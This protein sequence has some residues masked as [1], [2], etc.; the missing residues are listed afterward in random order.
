[1]EPIP[2]GIHV[3][4]DIFKCIPLHENLCI[5]FKISLNFLSKGQTNKVSVSSVDSLGA[6]YTGGHFCTP[7]AT[8]GDRR[9]FFFRLWLYQRTNYDNLFF[10]ALLLKYNHPYTCIYVLSR[11]LLTRVFLPSVIHLAQSYIVHPIITVHAHPFRM[12]SMPAVRYDLN[13]GLPTCL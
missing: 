1:M 2:G 11:S 7:V 8:W 4:N 5:S 9:D 12:V 6:E 10:Q 13:G 3:T